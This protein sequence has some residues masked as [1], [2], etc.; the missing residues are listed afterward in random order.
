MRLSD[1]DYDLPPERIAQEPAARREDARLFVHE[2]VA[3]V[4]RHRHA[5]DLAD[6]LRAGDL[7]V[8]ND[9]RVVPARVWGR[10][11]SGGVVE[12]LLHERLPGA[13]DRWRALANPG[14][15]LKVGE[16]IALVDGIGWGLRLL[17]RPLD[18]NGRPGPEW[19]VEWVDRG[20]EPKTAL[21]ALERVGHVPLPPYIERERE[22]D[23]ADPR[24]AAD[25]ERYQTV[26]A[27]EPG[28][29]AAPTAGLH[30]T[31]ELF[32][33]L[34]ARGV[35]QAHVTL[36]VGLGTFRPVEAD[37]PR[38]HR[39]HA[40]RYELSEQTARA[41]AACRARGGRVVAVGTTSVRVLET[42]ADGAGGVRAGAGRTDLFMVPGDSFSVVDALVTNFHMPKSTLLMLV[43]AFAGRERVLRI[44]AEALAEGYRFLSYGDAMLLV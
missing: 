16:T 32:T 27:R 15:R 43:S 36:H 4:T 28:A 26:Y 33:E 3:D 12:F 18:A 19:I 6:E 10:R 31:P 1:F 11:A 7:L 30:F 38:E 9:T 21:E 24:A 17:E 41:V 13:A 5:R 37:D 29:V 39:M 25:R 20:P 14:R 42:C 23:S 44:Y 34:A 22:R 2:R 35:D 40:E 8:M